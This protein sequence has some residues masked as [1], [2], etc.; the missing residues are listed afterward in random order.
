M[1]C[2]VLSI[3]STQC[4][5]MYQFEF[6]ITTA[7]PKIYVDIKSTLGLRQIFFGG[8]GIS[9]TKTFVTV[10][11]NLNLHFLSSFQPLGKESF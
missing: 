2:F 11:F 6:L 7:L 5:C 8:G 4:I 9:H 10:M 1:K 3:K